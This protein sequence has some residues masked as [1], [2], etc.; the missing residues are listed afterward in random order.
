MSSGRSVEAEEH[1]WG[2][3]LVYFFPSIPAR[4]TIIIYIP[5][6]HDFDGSASHRTACNSYSPARLSMAPSRYTGAAQSSTVSS[7]YARGGSVSKTR[8]PSGIKSVGSGGSKLADGEVAE[9]VEIEDFRPPEWRTVLNRRADL[10]ECS[11][12]LGNWDVERVN[13]DEPRLS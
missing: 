4:V 1:R 3:V 9:Q 13:T 7:A 10:G 8:R 11:L 5:S 2:V 6:S 12:M